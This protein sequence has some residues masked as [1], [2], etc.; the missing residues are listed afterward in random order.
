MSFTSSAFFVSGMQLPS[1]LLKVGTNTQAFIGNFGDGRF[2]L[3]GVDAGDGIGGD[4]QCFEPQTFDH[5]EDSEEGG[6]L[7]G[8]G[9]AGTGNRLEAHDE[10]LH[11]AGG[12]DDVGRGEFAAP[13]KRVPG[14]LAAQFRV[15]LDIFVQHALVTRVAQG[16]EHRLLQLRRPA[17]G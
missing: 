16:V 4:L 8:D 6:V 12:H 9:I 2:E 5:L 1:G 7:D 3:C 14:Q 15:A 11:A 13:A 10:R 17:A